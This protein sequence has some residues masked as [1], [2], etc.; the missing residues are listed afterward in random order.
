[1]KVRQ[2]TL[3]GTLAQVEIEPVE[4][5]DRADPQH[6]PSPA[7]ASQARMMS[8]AS[9]TTIR[10]SPPSRP[11]MAELLQT[12]ARVISTTP[13][14]D[15]SNVGTEILRNEPNAHGEAPPSTPPVVA[16]TVPSTELRAG[17]VPSSPPPTAPP[18]VA[19]D[20]W[21]SS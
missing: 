2:A 3:D 16:G 4:S 14:E 18:P 5:P 17:P 20:F 8:P 11:A 10:P 19:T 21:S 1:M 9:A 6:S 13:E 12:V 7:P 15:A